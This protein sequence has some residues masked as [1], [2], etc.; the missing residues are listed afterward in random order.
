M[1]QNKIRGL[2]AAFALA[3]VG[4]GRDLA[5][6]SALPHIVYILADDLGYGDPGCYNDASKIPTPHIDELARQGIRF[7]DAHAPSSVCTPTR[8]GIL[9][10]R[11]CWRTD[12]TSGVLDGFDPPLI[13]PDRLTVPQLLRQH[14]YRTACIGK[15]HLGMTWQSTAAEPMALHG[16]PPRPGTK[17]D[18]AAPP[19]A[20]QPSRGFDQW[21]GISASLDMSPYC[22]LDGDGLVNVPNRPLPE[23][24]DMFVG[25]SAGVV[26]PGFRPVDVLPQLGRR[27]AAVIDNH[28]RESANR[29]LFLYFPLPAPHLPVVPVESVRGQG[30]AGRY[31]DFVVQVDQT[32]GL[33]LDALNRNHMQ[34]NSLVIVSSDNG[35]LWHWWEAQAPVDRQHGREGGRAEELRRFG[36]QSNGPW[37]GRKADIWEGGHRVPLVARWPARIPP[38]IVSDKLVELT[39]LLATCAAL[40]GAA[41][42]DNAGEDSFS[43]LPALLQE[44]ATQPGRDFAVHHSLHGM[45]AIRHGPWKLIEGRGSGGFSQPR[46]LE[47]SAGEPAGQIYH[48]GRDPQE[49]RNLW[50]ERPKIVQRLSSLLKQLRDSRRSRPVQSR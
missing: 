37:R 40:V 3:G 20:G 10:G 39:D 14:G 25:L 31:G 26:A 41:L 7:T 45:F 1:K 42:P 11:Y 27:A 35:G 21:F 12:L 4:A 22:F 33:V 19:R 5:H 47:A 30:R 6:A 32:I 36:H 23:A 24:S 13:E 29:P 34:Q 49:T 16:L 44:P 38:G 9:T 15:W 17:V 48:L 50:N 43:I 46:H 2:L 8:Y 28:A 18:F